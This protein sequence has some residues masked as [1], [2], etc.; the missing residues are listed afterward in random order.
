MNRKL[1]ATV[2][3]MF[4]LVPAVQ[5]VRAEEH[6]EKGEWKTKL[7]LSDDQVKKLDDLR[8]SE[9]AERKPIREKHHALVEKLEGQIKSKASDADLKATLDDI[10]ANHEAGEKIE[11]RYKQRRAEVL[12]PIQQAKMLVERMERH[13]RMEKAEKG[14]EQKEGKEDDD[15]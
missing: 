6:H 8:A 2:V 4:A 10:S 11:E 15:E 5:T 9:K 7:G 3:M 1:I 12:T 13:E 14:K